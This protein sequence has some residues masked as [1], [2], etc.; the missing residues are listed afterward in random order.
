MIMEFLDFC[1]TPASFSARKRGFVFEAIAFHHRAQRNKLAWSRHWQICHDLTRDLTRDF[2]EAK[3]LAIFGSGGLFEIPKDELVRHFDRLILVDQVFPREVR[4]WIKEGPFSKKIQLV[5]WDFANPRQ[6]PAQL[7]RLVSA[8]LVISANLLSQLHLRIPQIASFNSLDQAWRAVEEH[9]LDTLRQ[10]SGRVL[11]WTD[12]QIDYLETSSNRVSQ[13]DQTVLA[14]LPKP[15]IKEWNWDLAL[16]P[17]MY[18]TA[19]VILKMKA[20][21]L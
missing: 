19:D 10:F 4:K 11:L 18:P 6:S 12:T 17:E 9:H 5:E 2:A 16:A 15:W 21:R 13:T 14:K 7:L 1:R 20:L 8:D 3:S